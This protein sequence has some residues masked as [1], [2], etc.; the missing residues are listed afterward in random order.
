M[1]TPLI[2]EQNRQKIRIDSAQIAS[3]KTTR[4]IDPYPNTLRHIVVIMSVIN[5][6]R[7]NGNNPIPALK[8]FTIIVFREGRYRERI[9]TYSA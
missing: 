1:N 7:V 5:P 8:N 4:S 6:C 3:E 2:T 9:L